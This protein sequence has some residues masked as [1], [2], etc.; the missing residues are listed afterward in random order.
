MKRIAGLLA[1][2]SAIGM[3]QA[4]EVPTLFTNNEV[5][6]LLSDEVLGAQRGKYMAANSRSHYFGIEFITTIAGPGNTMITNGMQLNV[7][8][9]SNQPTIS[10]YSSAGDVSTSESGQHNTN[11]NAPNGSGVVQVAQ[12]A[13]NANQGINDFMLLSGGMSPQG[14]VLNKGHYRVNT[15]NGHT[16]SYQFNGSGIGMEYTSQDG[17]VTAAQTVRSGDGNKGFL[18]QFSING[19]H[20]LLS[21][22]AKI[23]MGDTPAAYTDLAKTLMHQLPMGIK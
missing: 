21:N 2:T 18:Q 4:T 1:L 23:Y 17:H 7:N 14:T 15:F 5:G 20:K 19:N 10:T 3:A 22:Q 9:A 13:G 8:L 12:I 16:V 11:S 6:V